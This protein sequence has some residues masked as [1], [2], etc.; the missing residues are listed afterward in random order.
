MGY[1]LG[2]ALKIL[3]EHTLMFRSSF[4]AKENSF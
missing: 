4:S 2:Q 1:E 3:T